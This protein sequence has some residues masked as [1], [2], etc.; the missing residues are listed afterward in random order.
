MTRFFV[1]HVDEDP[2][3]EA[4][5][6]EDI[7][8]YLDSHHLVH[9]NLEHETAPV[10]EVAGAYVKQVLTGYSTLTL[11]LKEMPTPVESTPKKRKR[12]KPRCDRCGKKMQ[13]IQGVVGGGFIWGCPCPP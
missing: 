1:S 10:E 9:L 12:K 4:Q 3:R 13:K 2:V 7:K 5:L 11:R 6:V 8:L